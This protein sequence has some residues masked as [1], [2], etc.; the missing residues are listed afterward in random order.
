MFF[1]KVRV[2]DIMYRCFKAKKIVFLFSFLFLRC[3]VFVSMRFLV[4]SISLL[5]AVAQSLDCQ[6][7]TP[8]SP[9]NCHCDANFTLRD[10]SLQLSSLAPVFATRTLMSYNLSDPSGAFGDR[11]PFFPQNDVVQIVF[12]ANFSQC[13]VRTNTMDIL[14]QNVRVKVH[15]MDSKKSQSLKVTFADKKRQFGV[16]AFVLKS[17][18]VRKEKK[19]KQRERIFKFF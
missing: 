11:H 19:E 15:G 17:S 16:E 9:S 2:F 1:N 13:S 4:V 14:L 7:G 8:Q 12:G 5:W 10:C 6:H 18:Q 3:F